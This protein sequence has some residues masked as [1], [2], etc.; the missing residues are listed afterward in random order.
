MAKARFAQSVNSDQVLYWL[1]RKRIRAERDRQERSSGQEKGIVDLL[2]GT[3][4]AEY[5]WNFCRRNL[6]NMILMT[7]TFEED[8]TAQT[9]SV[10]LSG[11][12]S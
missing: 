1:I 9:P 8:K 5:G 6:F 10:L 4:S 3:L 11:L 2:S 7:E 12:I